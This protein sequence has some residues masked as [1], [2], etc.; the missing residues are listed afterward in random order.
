MM[1][2]PEYFEKLDVRKPPAKVVDDKLTEILTEVFEIRKR[3]EKTFS[4]NELLAY[5]RILA[6]HL[7]TETLLPKLEL[8]I[9]KDFNLMTQI[10]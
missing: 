9:K 6:K 10:Q 5:D 1:H 3:L 4:R 7:T 8:E 2:I